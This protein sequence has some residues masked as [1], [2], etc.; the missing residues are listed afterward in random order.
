VSAPSE[1]QLVRYV[2]RVYD[3]V[4]W[5]GFEL[6]PDDIIISTAPKCGTTWTQMICALLILQTPELPDR[7]SNL[8]PW[9][10][11]RTRSRRSI[12]ELLDAQTHRRFIKTHTP[13]PGLPVREGVTYICVGRDPRDVA[14]SMDDHIA[15]LDW[16]EFH[17][18]AVAAAREDGLPEPEKVSPPPLDRLSET[19]RF[20]RWVD[21]DTPPEQTSS[22]LLRTLRHVETFWEAD[23][24]VD[25]V[26]LHYRDLTVDLE[27]E[28]RA[29]STRLG[30]EVPEE[31]WPALVEAATLASMRRTSEHTAPSPGIWRDPDG[32]FKRGR[33]A[34]W[35][36]VIDQDGERRYDARVAS[37]VSEDLAGWLHRS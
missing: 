1:R 25:V 29:L 10:D 31:R 32:F 17:A 27:G 15:N 9:L 30:I 24:T 8:S 5:E 28:M 33:S 3:S 35:L 12:V 2:G 4:R 36:D 26:M 13:L 16:D 23:G 11:M 19:E 34:A 7:L 37:L 22:S 6:R 20:W 21:D 14:L 18:R